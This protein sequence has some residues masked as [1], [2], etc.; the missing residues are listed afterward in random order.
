MAVSAAILCPSVC[1]SD[2]INRAGVCGHE[3]V[4]SLIFIFKYQANMASPS[5]PKVQCT[6]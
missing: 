2:V 3:A 1:I 6:L 5:F 4:L